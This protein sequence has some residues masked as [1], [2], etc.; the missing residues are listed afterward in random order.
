MDKSD[1]DLIEQLKGNWNRV[2]LTTHDQRE[3]FERLYDCFEVVGELGTGLIGGNMIKKI[4]NAE[5][6]S[7]I[8]VVFTSMLNNEDFVLGLEGLKQYS[9]I[10]NNTL[11]NTCIV[12]KDEKDFST[13]INV[14]YTVRNNLRHG[15]KEYTQRSEQIL[16]VLNKIFYKIVGGARLKYLS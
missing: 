7:E 13:V 3:L 8:K 1:E 10:K 14:I 9:P 11:A 5:R 16:R 2:K 4:K 15:K 6:D 12:I